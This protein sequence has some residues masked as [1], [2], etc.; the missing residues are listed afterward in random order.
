MIVVS[1][2]EQY[3]LHKKSLF[4]N[5]EH[6]AAEIMK[7]TEPRQMKYLS[8]RIKALDESKWLPHAKKTMEKACH[9]KFTQNLELKQ[10]LLKSK[11]TLVEANRNDRYFSCG[12]SL[13]NPNIME[14]SK[15]CG[16]NHLGNILTQLRS[17]LQQ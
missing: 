12:L 8:H 9:L 6:T 13:A 3:Y 2:S 10:K 14:T 17:S 5:D 7:C 11:G 16:E 15:W 4:F 1:C